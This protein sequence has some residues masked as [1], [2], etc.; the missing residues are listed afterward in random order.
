MKTVRVVA[1]ICFMI[2]A[3]LTAIG[4]YIII[5]DMISLYDIADNLPYGFLR[6]GA[7]YLFGLL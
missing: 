6:D 5:N 1:A 4:I 2:F 3:V 7:F